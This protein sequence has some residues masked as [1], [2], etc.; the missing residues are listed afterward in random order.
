MCSIQNTDAMP[1]LSYSHVTS[2]NHSII[3]GIQ[4]PGDSQVEDKTYAVLR[5]KSVIKHV[6][7]LNYLKDG[8]I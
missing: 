7:M 6:I 3:I 2:A 8:Y 5:V 4:V 1:R